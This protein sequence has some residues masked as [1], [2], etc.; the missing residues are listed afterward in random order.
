VTITERG[1]IRNPI[2]RAVARYVF[3]YGA[4]MEAFLD[5]LRAHIG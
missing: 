5:E 2:F 3:G 4:T 1:E